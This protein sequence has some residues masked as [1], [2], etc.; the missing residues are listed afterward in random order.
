MPVQKLP[1]TKK[2]KMCLHSVTDREPKPEETGTGWKVIDVVELPTL[3][4]RHF[5]GPFFNQE[6]YPFGEW[7]KAVPF[8]FD[9]GPPTLDYTPGFHIFLNKKDAEI[10]LEKFINRGGT[11]RRVDNNYERT[12]FIVV[13]VEYKGVLCR[14]NMMCNAWIG[15]CP[16]L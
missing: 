11:H 5:Y 12:N 15:I 8:K 2:I 16:P 1:Q 9:A 10:Y 14:G 6:P 13:Q 7:V 4:K 3:Q